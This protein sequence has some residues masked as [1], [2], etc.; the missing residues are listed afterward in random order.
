MRA[1]ARACV[2]A[3]VRACMCLGDMEGDNLRRWIGRNATHPTL[4]SAPPNDQ[5]QSHFERPFCK[6]DKALCSHA[7]CTTHVADA[8]GCPSPLV[9]FA[10]GRCGY[11]RAERVRAALCSRY[12]LGSSGLWTALF[13]WSKL[14]ELLDTVGAKTE[15]LDSRHSTNP[16][17]INLICVSCQ[18]ANW[19]VEQ[20]TVRPCTPFE[21]NCYLVSG[22]YSE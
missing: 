14:P 13:V 11:A 21:S 5:F 2:R 18:S 22:I 12:L 3:C 8:A 10:H 16:A 20:N 6:C 9:G 15:W 4:C 17:H 1:C 19:A 7:T